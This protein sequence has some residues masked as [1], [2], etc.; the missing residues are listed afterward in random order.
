MD[1]VDNIVLARVARPEKVGWSV[2]ATLSR[3]ALVFT[4]RLL[5]KND[6]LAK[7]FVY[8]VNVHLLIWL[9]PFTGLEKT[10]A[11]TVVLLSCLHFEPPQCV[12]CS[13]GGQKVNFS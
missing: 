13:F 2:V 12:M 9:L 10:A 7:I 8:S 3:V 1:G 6:K 4:T 11:T 5:Q